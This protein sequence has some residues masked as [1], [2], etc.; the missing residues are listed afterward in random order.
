MNLG[1]SGALDFGAI[2]GFNIVSGA[3]QVGP[4]GSF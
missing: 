2:V 4:A 1:V 3:Q